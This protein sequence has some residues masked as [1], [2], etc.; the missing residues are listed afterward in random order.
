M[1]IDGKPACYRKLS[2]LSIETEEKTDKNKMEIVLT[3]LKAEFENVPDA[4]VKQYL[5]I[6]KHPTIPQLTKFHTMSFVCSGSIPLSVEASSDL[7]L[8][9][10][11]KSEQRVSVQQVFATGQAAEILRRKSSSTNQETFNFFSKIYEGRAQRQL[12]AA[13]N[14]EYNIPSILS[15]SS[16]QILS[17]VHRE[18]AS[19]YTTLGVQV[20]NGCTKD[21]SEQMKEYLV[22]NYKSNE[23]LKEFK[24]KKKFNNTLVISSK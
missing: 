1:S 6:E 3:P 24:V 21:F 15:E 11:Q 5:F 13:P 4:H 9:V 8:E 23:S 2:K 18:I 7:Y 22:E 16:V 10:L 20:A 19:S 14:C 17:N 12:E